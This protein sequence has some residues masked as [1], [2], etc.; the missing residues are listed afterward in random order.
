MAGDSYNARLL[1]KGAPGQKLIKL[2]IDKEQTRDKH[3]AILL[4]KL[5]TISNAE[6]GHAISELRTLESLALKVLES[7]DKEAKEAFFAASTS[8]GISPTN[9]PLL[10]ADHATRLLLA[11]ENNWCQPL[12]YM[13]Y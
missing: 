5:E 6:A 4:A 7:L 1:T 11:A 2:L 10:S 13:G 9:T 3:M 12:N 8:W